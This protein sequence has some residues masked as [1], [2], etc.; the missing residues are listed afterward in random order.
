VRSPYSVI[1]RAQH[2]RPVTPYSPQTAA[3]SPVV[4]RVIGWRTLVSTLFDLL[5]DVAS[6]IAGDQDIDVNGSRVGLHRNR[7]A[8]IGR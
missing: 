2:L 3:F 4:G 7:S 5:Q 1:N 6:G 8:M